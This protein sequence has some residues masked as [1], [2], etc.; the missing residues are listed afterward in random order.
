MISMNECHG[1][2]GKRKG[3]L[4]LLHTTELRI[5]RASLATHTNLFLGQNKNTNSE[6]RRNSDRP[7]TQTNASRSVSVCEQRNNAGAMSKSNH[8]GGNA[9]LHPGN[10]IAIM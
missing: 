8:R 4:F 5:I 3:K 10:E 7:T 9:I 1:L 6:R 2:K